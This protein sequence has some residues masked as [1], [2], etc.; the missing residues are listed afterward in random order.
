MKE[1]VTMRDLSNRIAGVAGLVILLGA[2]AATP[3][4]ANGRPQDN[5][6][7]LHEAG[8]P[9]LGACEDLQVPEG[10]DLAFLAYAEG[11]QIYKW[12]GSGWIFLGPEADLFAD[13]EGNGQIGIHYAGPTWESVSGSRVVGAVEKRCTPDAN[14]IPWL[15]L[16]GTFSEGPGIFD[17]VTFILR[18][19]TTGGNAPAEPGVVDEVRRVPYTAVYA[20][21][22]A[23][24]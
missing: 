14:A 23:H 10:N 24:A 18:L 3:I 6:T 22:R 8:A 5:G 16:R 9:D 7:S 21:Y 19:E 4:N 15:R 17:G 13:D 11:V 2:F 1:R 12:N 20:F